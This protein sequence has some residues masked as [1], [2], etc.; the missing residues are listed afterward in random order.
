MTS[1]LEFDLLLLARIDQTDLGS[2]LGGEQF[3]HVVAQRL[4]SGDHLAGLHEEPDDVGRRT[5][6]LRAEIERSR[7]PL[8]DNLALGDRCIHR[9]V[10][11]H[12]HRLEFFAVATATTLAAG[13]TLTGTTRTATRTATA[14]GATRTTAAAR[15]GAPAPGTE[16]RGPLGRRPPGMGP[17]PDHPD[18]HHWARWDGH[19]GVAGSLCPK[20]NA[21]EEVEES[22]CPSPRSAVASTDRQQ[23]S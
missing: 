7:G 20:W 19:P 4:G 17:Q 9:R 13:R 8:D 18:G 23:P 12:I 11:R 1:S 6:E 14:T 15:R 16:S 5:V 10:A 2:D 21:A 22:A 3:D